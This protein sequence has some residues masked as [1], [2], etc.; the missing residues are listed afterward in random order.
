MLSLS[1]EEKGAITSVRVVTN[2]DDSLTKK[3]L[4]ILKKWRMEPSHDMNG[5]PVPV[6]FAVEIVFRLLS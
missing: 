2:P 3:A 6:R 1:L 4:G 5:N